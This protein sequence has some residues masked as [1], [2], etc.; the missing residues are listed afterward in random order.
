MAN[1]EQK[2]KTI[3]GVVEGEVKPANVSSSFEGESKS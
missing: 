3:R 1:E 2:G